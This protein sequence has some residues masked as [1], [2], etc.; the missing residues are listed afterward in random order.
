MY[1]YGNNSY[2]L[3]PKPRNKTNAGFKI[4]KGQNKN[5][6]TEKLTLGVREGY[7]AGG[8]IAVGNK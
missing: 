5:H 2:H 3:S 8:K 6:K 7:T 1:F 4:I